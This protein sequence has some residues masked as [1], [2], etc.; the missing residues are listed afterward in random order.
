MHGLWDHCHYTQ[1]MGTTAPDPRASRYHVPL[2][3]ARAMLSLLLGT[4]GLFPASMGRHL[5]PQQATCLLL[6]LELMAGP[7]WEKGLTGQR[8]GQENP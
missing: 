6:E 1:L 2:I 4:M 7:D 5:R 8:R 3:E